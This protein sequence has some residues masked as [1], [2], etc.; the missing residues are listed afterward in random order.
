MR[1]P[2][3]SAARR[4][5]Q[6]VTG[7]GALI[8]L[9]I[10]L[11]GAPAALIAFAG[12]PLP[13]HLP[14]LAEIGTAL[15]S[16]DDGQ[17]F[18]RALAVAGWLGWATFLLSVL[19]EIPA[20]LLRRSA[21][22]LPGLSRQ[23]RVAAALVGSI[24]LILV[25][26][27]AAAFAGPG[28]AVSTV[29]TTVAATTA[30]TGPAAAD[31]PTAAGH[32]LTPNQLAASVGRDGAGT[33]A[34]LVAPAALT[35]LA[36]AAPSGPA[37]PDEAPVYRVAKGDYLGHI[38]DRYLGEFG[39][40]RQLA[41]INDIQ[42]P[43]R[44]RAGQLIEL[45]ADAADSGVRRH[46]TGSVV[47]PAG[48]PPTGQPSPER[49]TPPVEQTPPV[50]QTPPAVETPAPPQAPPAPADGP[51]SPAVPSAPGTAPAEQPAWQVGNDQPTGNFGGNVAAGRS[52][53]EPELN[54]PLA[55]AAV[56]T[57]ASIVGAQIG[58]MLGLKRR[59]AGAPAESGRHRRYRE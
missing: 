4:L 10:L 55:V 19:V 57:A 47:G 39:D 25:A 27:P 26:S 23:Q 21:P 3:V 16:R 34:P 2:R 28:P 5:G 22:K 7:L 58:T 53:P 37:Q 29:A 8:I 9:L 35:T 20:R 24:S 1:A 54:R 32:Q 50:G 48:A 6:V 15:T 33:P 52:G 18:L 46:A 45:P 56:I 14:G 30:T 59:A 41:E 49:E 31:Q 40:Y 44:I 51:V 17:L 42:N 38:A 43:D 12:N 11:A 13:D 36:A